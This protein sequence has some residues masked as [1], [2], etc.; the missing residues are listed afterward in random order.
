MQKNSLCGGTQA[1]EK[2]IVHL[3][4]VNVALIFL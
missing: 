3:D 2:E 1:T 4:K